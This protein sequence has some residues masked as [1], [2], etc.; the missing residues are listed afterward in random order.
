MKKKIFI[1]LGV[2][3]ILGVFLSFAM[4]KIKKEKECEYCSI[5][6]FSESNPFGL[7]GLYGE[8][9]YELTKQMG[10]GWI[11]PQIGWKFIEPQNDQFNWDKLDEIYNEYHQK[12]GFNI[13]ISLRTGQLEWATKYDPDLCQ[14][15]KDKEKGCP[16]PYA[17]LLPKDLQSTWSNQYGYSKSYYDFVFKTVEHFKGRVDYY[18]IENEVNTLTFWHGTP[19][20]YLQLRA[21]AYKAAHDASS[22]VVIIDN[23]IASGV[24]GYAIARDKYCSG[25]S[26]G[27]LEF[28][29]MFFQRQMSP[30]EIDKQIAQNAIDCQNPSRA[31]QFLKATFKEPTFDIASY[32]FYEPWQ[33]QSE[34][35][36]WVKNEMN[37]NGY[38][39]PIFC[40]EGGYFDKLH[41]QSD[42]ETQKLVSQDII[43]LHAIAFG[44]GVKKWV[45][46]PLDESNP[47]EES[48]Q[49]KGL[50]NATYTELPAG[51]AYKTM[52]KKIL[53]FS[54]VEKLNLGSGIYAYKFVVDE[55]PVYILW[56]DS[57]KTMDFSFEITGNVKVTRTDGGTETR[58]SSDLEITESPVFIE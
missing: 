1:I 25:D 2:V 36:A 20:E 49:Y 34:V 30:D 16:D 10:V 39:K 7:T 19:E 38:Q 35:I 26:Q 3:I 8:K 23:G 44:E 24:W 11:R 13:M 28:F 42:I 22:S 47:S 41:S 37:N 53:G 43:K 9:D 52:L 33:A 21:T 48:K 46:L 56:S 54:S 45:W 40:T 15:K 5:N 29:K 14:Y 32:H 17:S 6:Y 57:P 27:A 12:Y 31:Y 58:Q 4:E 55:K 18:V 50:Y 51:T